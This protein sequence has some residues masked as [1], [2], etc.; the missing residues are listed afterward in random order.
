MTTKASLLIATG[1]FTAAVTGSDLFA[2]MTIARSSLDIALAEDLHWVSATVAG[3]VFLFA[4]F[5]GVA[6][7]CGSANTRTKTR[8]AIALFVVVLTVLDY[9]YSMTS[10]LLNR[11]C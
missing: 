3:I 5:L 7:I 2:R 4:P 9:F 10:K 11:R 6:F 1:V 8:S